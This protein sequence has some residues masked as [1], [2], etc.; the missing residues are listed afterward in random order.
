MLFMLL[1]MLVLID[2]ILTCSD[3]SAQPI[4]WCKTIDAGPNFKEMYEWEE[5]DYLGAARYDVRNIDRG[6]MRIYIV[7]N[8]MVAELNDGGLHGDPGKT[9]SIYW[10]WESANFHG[11]VFISD[12][13]FVVLDN[14]SNWLSATQ[15]DKW[16]PDIRDIPEEMYPGDG[17]VVTG[18]SVE[19]SWHEVDNVDYYAIYVWDRQPDIENFSTGLY[20]YNEI[21]TDVSLT[22]SSDYLNQ[23]GTYYWILIAYD[24][25]IWE[26]GGMEISQFEYIAD[27]VITPPPIETNKPISIY[28]N[29][30]KAGNAIFIAN[31][32]APVQSLSIIDITGRV[33]LNKPLL[34][35]NR[36]FSGCYS[37]NSNSIPHGLYFLTLSSEAKSRANGTQFVFKFLVN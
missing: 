18:D 34:E 24:E 31:L 23:A 33:I 9:D 27:N 17:E 29:P 16:F 35:E 20:Y 7:T 11:H 13:T 10:H 4:S 14:D 3:L 21:L 12:V 6:I 26:G 8:W 36:S 19:F 30:V 2:V 15:P 37:L 25:I 22:L 28:P 32:N 5:G 1:F